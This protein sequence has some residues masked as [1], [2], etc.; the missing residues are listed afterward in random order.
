MS[1]Q[2][3]HFN[4]LDAYRGL[5]A[6]IVVVTHSSQ[7]LRGST[8]LTSYIHIMQILVANCGL[9]GFFLLSSFLLTYRLYSE[10]HTLPFSRDSAS[11]IG[12]Y[13]IRRFMRI[14][15]PFC[16]FLTLGRILP[17]ILPGKLHV[18]IF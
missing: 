9:S 18:F 12:R 8:Q 13:F 5:M 3:I 6:L 1:S 7:V 4:F 10:L 14:Y 16:V 15:V 11:V 2:L 17:H